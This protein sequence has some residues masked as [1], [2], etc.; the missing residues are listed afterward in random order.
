MEVLLHYRKIFSESEDLEDRSFT[1]LH[2][3]VLGL[4]HRTA[5]TY[6]QSCSQAEIDRS[7]ARGLT[8]L[9]WAASRGDFDTVD[10]LLQEGADPNNLTPNGTSALH[11]AVLRKSLRCTDHI[12]NHGADVN[13]R[14]RLRF[15]PLLCICSFSK[16][17]IA[18]VKRLI[19]RGA[20]IDAQDFQGATSL[21][22]ASQYNST[23][24]VQCLL[25]HNAA[26]D[27]QS[28]QG[29]TALTTS[30][31]AN[32]HGAMSILLAHGASFNPISISGRSLLHEAADCGDEETLRLL[33]AAHMWGIDIKAKTSDGHTAW[34]L[35]R[36][37]EDV[38]PEWRAAFLGL[39]ESVNETAKEAAEETTSQPSVEQSRW[40]QFELRRALWLRPSTLVKSVE[41]KGYQAVLCVSRSVRELLR[42]GSWTFSAL[43]LV[44][45]IAWYAVT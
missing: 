11:F 3:V 18:C 4:D 23:T 29:E 26:I 35:A 16:P 43:L 10:L 15:T 7:D 45:A 44:L 42:L 5:K 28:F 30:I 19:E 12:L 22:F 6:A 33:T 14:D 9:H 37:R 17:D 8:P 34:D 31:Q 40:F 24:V 13:V 21:I 32:A 25:E 20:S 41:E 27:K 2:R 1:V 38:T 36:K 39:L